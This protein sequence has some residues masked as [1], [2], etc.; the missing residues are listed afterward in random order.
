MERKLAAMHRAYGTDPLHKC[1]TCGNLTRN[2]YNRVYFKCEIYGNSSS[3]ATD[4]AMSWAACGMYNK[5]LPAY[6]RTMIN[7]L[8]HAKRKSEVY[9]RAEGQMDIFDMEGTGRE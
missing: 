2:T 8:K 7:I 9:E 3:V 5:P 6:Q 4:W 1:G